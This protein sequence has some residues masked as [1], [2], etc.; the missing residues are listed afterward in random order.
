MTAKEKSKH[1]LLPM[2]VAERTMERLNIKDE[3]GNFLWPSPDDPADIIKDLLF[4]MRSLNK[5]ETN[6]FNRKFGNECKQTLTVSQANA[7]NNDLLANP[8]IHSRNSRSSSQRVQTSTS[9]CSWKIVVLSL[10][11][12]TN[13]VKVLR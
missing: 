9:T 8:C 6:T 3:N 5:E 10:S 11:S 2:S 12:E 1:R 13:S 4:R 7:I